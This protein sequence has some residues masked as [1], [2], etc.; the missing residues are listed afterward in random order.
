MSD[1]TAAPGW[2]H[3]EG[4]PPGTERYWDGSAWT[5]GP[6]PVASSFPPPTTPA[7]PQAPAAPQTPAA[8]DMPIM[9]GS[10]E[11]T[12]WSTNEPAVVPA[13]AG[14][15][16]PTGPSFGQ[17]GAFVNYPEDSKAVW[18]LVL[19]I[20]GFLCCG[21]PAGI[22]A[23]LA[24]QERKA[25]DEGRRDPKNRGMAVASIVIAVLALVVWVVIYGSW[26]LVAS[27]GELTPA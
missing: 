20:G 1:G 9:P 19:S 5:D 22:G 18:A 23:Y 6:R 17:P 7:A 8:P 2:Y 21:L 11:A 24:N 10:Q 4:D 27:L 3:A 14:M 13:S 12:P 26:I 15:Q 25:I 16:P